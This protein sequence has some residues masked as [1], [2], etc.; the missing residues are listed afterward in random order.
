VSS[1]P[2]TH[3]SEILAEH[4]GAELLNLARQGISNSAIRVQIDEAVRRK[5]D[6]ILIGATV[7]DRLVFP[8]NPDQKSSGKITVKDFN[9]D[10]NPDSR[11]LSETLLNVTD[12][13]RQRRMPNINPMSKEAVRQYAA[14][15]HDD[16]WQQQLDRYLLNEGLWQLHDKKIEFYYNPWLNIKGEMGMP[17]WFVDRYFL[18]FEFGFQEYYH[19]YKLTGLDD[20]GYHI[21]A[22]GQRAFAERLLD[23]I[24]GKEIENTNS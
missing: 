3:W 20:P 24:R 12:G 17:R 18:P 23:Y 6:L 5:A 21:S 16:N 10:D 1:V 7:S 11:L 13:P 22:E 8:R 2:D 14:F 19:R 9:Y 15:L 4:L